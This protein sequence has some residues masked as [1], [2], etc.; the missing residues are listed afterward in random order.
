[1]SQSVMPHPE[2]CTCIVTSKLF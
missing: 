2:Y 1:M